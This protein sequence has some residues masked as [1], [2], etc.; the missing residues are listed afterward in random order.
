[1]STVFDASRLKKIDPKTECL[2]FGYIRSSFL[3][4]NAILVPE[5]PIYI[6]LLYYTQYEFWNIAGKDII[7]LD[8][9]NAFDTIL[10]SQVA[11]HWANT[12]YGN[13]KVLSTDNCICEWNIKMYVKNHGIQLGL[14][15]NNLRTHSKAFSHTYD[16]NY[17][18]WPNIGNI[19]SSFNESGEHWIKFGDKVTIDNTNFYIKL[20]LSK[21]EISYSINDQ[22]QG[23]AFRHI[24]KAKGVK[25]NLAASLYKKGSMLTITDFHCSRP[26]LL[27]IVDG[28][29]NLLNE[30]EDSEEESEKEEEE[31]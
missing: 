25:Y 23:V 2:I 30:S 8:K 21:R 22:D 9:M 24:V 5:L 1:M 15:T 27:D 28:A 26:N 17:L 14:T 16:N 20:D 3:I 6:V 11:N 12:S 7:I 18:F 19:K 10:H 13:V 31:D 29:I 4:Q